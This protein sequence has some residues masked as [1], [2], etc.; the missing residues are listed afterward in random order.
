MSGGSSDF[1]IRSAAFLG[2]TGVGLGAFGAHAL[3]PTLEK[4]KNGVENWKTAVTYQL[5]HATALLAL[6]ALASSNQAK[7][8]GQNFSQRCAKSGTFMTIGSMLFSG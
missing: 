1:L 4:Q 3:K 6:S 2:S 5:L 8:L 7:T